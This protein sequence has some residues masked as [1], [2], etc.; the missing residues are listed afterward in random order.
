MQYLT[1][2]RRNQPFFRLWM[3]QAVSYIGDWFNYIAASLIINRY[4]NTSG[5][6]IGALILARFLPPLLVAPMAGVLVDRMNR[7]RLMVISDVLRALVVFC[8]LLV[9][10]SNWMWLPYLLLIIQSAIGAIFEPSRSAFL[11]SVVEG[12][13]LVTA[14][15]LSSVTWSVMLAVGAVSG[16][17][18]SGLLGTDV[19]FVID[20]LSFVVS[21]AFIISIGSYYVPLPARTAET[22]QHEGSFRE[23]LEYILRHPA[24]AATLFVKLGGNIGSF[25][26]LL[27]LYTTKVF[28]LGEGGSLSIGLLYTAF[29]L[30]AV[31]GPLIIDR[32]NDQS[33]K[34]M[35]RLIAVGYA[36]I[37]LGLLLMAGAPIFVAA[38][39]AVCIKAMGSS[40]YWTYSSVILQKTVEDRFLGRVFAFDQAGFQ[41]ATVVSTV[42]TGAI[43]EGVTAEGVRAVILGTAVVSF[44][45]FLLWTLALP[46][47]ESH[48][49]HEGTAPLA[50]A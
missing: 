9:N 6:A 25:D 38:G 4:S 18:V 1:L 48:A 10:E 17:V 33:V 46:W 19:A 12:P 5:I 39:I 35:R 29:G 50:E 2:L 14:N 21:A 30:G 26:A 7:H 45:P 20:G 32:F 43:T 40:V 37:A 15:L 16:G 34:Q 23:G 41:L 8:F 47:I 27:L 28:V 36:L 31:F 3:A 42:I 13:D 44:L 11:P 22:P 49:K 24:T